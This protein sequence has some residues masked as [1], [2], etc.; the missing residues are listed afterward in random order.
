MSGNLAKLKHNVGTHRILTC[1]NVSKPTSVTSGMKHLSAWIIAVGYYTRRTVETQQ[2]TFDNNFVK[3]M[4]TDPNN[5][6]IAV[7]GEHI[8][9]PDIQSKIFHIVLKICQNCH[10]FT[11]GDI[12]NGPTAGRLATSSKCITTQNY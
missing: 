12:F 6:C 8:N 7:I 10:V 9:S 1:N 4:L 5:F 2:F 3:V 11:D